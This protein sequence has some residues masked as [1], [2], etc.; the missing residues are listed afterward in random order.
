MLMFSSWCNVY[1]VPILVKYV[2][3]LAI[4]KWYH[5]PCTAGVSLVL[6]AF[7]HKTEYRAVH[8]KGNMNVCT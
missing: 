8:P 6:Q 2:S 7:S 1:H 4:A 3:M 5:T